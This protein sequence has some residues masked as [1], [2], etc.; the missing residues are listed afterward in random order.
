MASLIEELIDTLD[1]ENNEYTELL[2]L[3]KQKTPIIING[4]IETL[5]NITAKEQEHT[6][7][8]A[9][10]ENKRTQV[11]EDIATVL[12]MDVKTITVKKIIDLL[13]GQEKE[14]NALAE[15]HDKLKM[16]LNDMAVIN[17]MNK[18]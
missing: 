17:D 15:V 13:N 11:V 6:D 5:N 2:E 8:L 9:A 10:L 16:T 4:E 14:Q 7:K 12:N 3:S 18:Q 1:L